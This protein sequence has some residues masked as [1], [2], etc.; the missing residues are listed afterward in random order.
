MLERLSE[1]MKG[2]LPGLLGLQLVHIETGKAEARLE[3]R[4]ELL[5]PN[6]FLHAGT[7]ITMA[8][9]CAGMGCLATLPKEAGGFTTIELKSNFFASARDGALRCKAWM[10]HGG[11]RT[12]V[13]DA[14]V[15]R[16]ADERVIALFRCTQFLL[17]REDP[18]TR[19]QQTARR[20]AA[21]QQHHQEVPDA[22]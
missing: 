8:D 6:D 11:S 18:R 2:R 19:R 9:S 20:I 1:G 4:P 13:W 15:S 16:E 12:Q 21:D 5:A 10:V 17:P 14:E 22:G 3:L 7:I